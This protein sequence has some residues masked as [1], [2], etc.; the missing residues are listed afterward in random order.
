MTTGGNSGERKVTGGNQ[1]R[2]WLAIYSNPTYVFSLSNIHWGENK[3]EQ[4]RVNPSCQ[5]SIQCTNCIDI[6]PGNGP[7]FQQSSK[8]GAAQRHVSL[9]VKGS[10]TYSL[11]LHPLESKLHEGK[12]LLLATRNSVSRTELSKYLLNAWIL[13]LWTCKC[14]SAHFP[15]CKIGRTIFT[16]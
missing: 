7:N 14:F 2:S 5:N 1:R 6:I 3:G 9:E 11:K 16:S 15:F 10:V 13:V 8:P 4:R 12:D